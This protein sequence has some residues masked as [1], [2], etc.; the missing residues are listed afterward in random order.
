M[1][2]ESLWDAS[3]RQRI[4]SSINPFDYA[5][6][7]F[8]VLGRLISGSG[9]TTDAQVKDMIERVYPTGLKTGDIEPWREAGGIAIKHI[10]A[11]NTIEEL[12]KWLD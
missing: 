3:T 1:G 2:D 4:V 7:P 9:D 10:S 6:N 12:K 11:T 5:Q 8:K